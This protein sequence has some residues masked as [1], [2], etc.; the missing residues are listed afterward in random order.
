MK[1]FWNL[2]AKLRKKAEYLPIHKLL[3]EIYDQTSFE[4]L[5]RLQPNGEVRAANLQMLVQKALDFENTSYR[6]L[7]NFVRYIEN[8]QKYEVD[9]GVAESSAGNENA[10][11]I[12]SIHKSKGLEFPIVFVSG[13]SKKFNKQDA[14]ER[15]ALHPELGLGVDAIDPKRRIKIPTIRKKMIQKQ[16]ELESLGEELRVLY[17]AL[18]RAK[19][20]ITE[21]DMISLFKRHKKEGTKAYRREMAQRI[22]GKRIRYVTERINGVEEVIGKDGCISIKGDELIVSTYAKNNMRCK[23]DEMDASELLSKDGVV[24]TAPDIEQGGEVHTII[25][26]YVYYR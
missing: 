7:F 26:H 4:Q 6:G 5:V 14:R 13:L 2:T 22:S 19:E 15:I 10:V 16:I 18:T 3:W 9:M 8:L 1:K 12:M 25:A 23:I 24:I 17:V 20:K 21:A 11:R